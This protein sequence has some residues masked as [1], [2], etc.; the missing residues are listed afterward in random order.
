[1]ILGQ[2]INQGQIPGPS[3]WI[4]LSTGYKSIQWITQCRGGSR[5]FFRR[6][7]TRLQLYFN[8]NKPHSFFLAEYQL[9]QRTAGHL[10]G[11]GGVHTPCTLPLD[12][13]LQ[14]FPHHFYIHLIVIYPVDSTIQHL[15]NRGQENKQGFNGKQPNL[16]LS[17]AFEDHMADIPN[18]S[19][20][21]RCNTKCSLRSTSIVL[22]QF[23]L[24]SSSSKAFGCNNNWAQFVFCTV[25]GFLQG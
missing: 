7:C 3:C 5:I 1:M 11:G 16:L 12:P 22:T 21:V 19:C 24:P 20:E 9:Y 14:W 10:R 4:T 17:I 23:Q 25:L 2:Y 18:K 13:P 6:G 15:N 8:T